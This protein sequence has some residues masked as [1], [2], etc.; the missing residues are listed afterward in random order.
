MSASRADLHAPGFTLVEA[1]IAL[2]VIAAAAAA[3]LPALGHALRAKTEREAGLDAVL[4]AQSLLEAY[5]PPGAARPGRREGQ[6]AAGPWI[7]EIGQGEEGA[8]GVVLRP[9]RVVLGAVTLETLRPGP[10]EERRP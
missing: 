10:V 6:S 2:L 7:I 9:V 4:T 5:A 3:V 1:L 8:R